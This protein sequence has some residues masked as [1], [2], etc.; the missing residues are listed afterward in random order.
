MKPLSCDFCMAFWSTPLPAVLLL[1]DKPV[2]ASLVTAV[3]AIGLTLFL[4][5]KKALMEPPPP[6]LQWPTSHDS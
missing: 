3:S 6:E 4:L 1:W 5:K 2:G